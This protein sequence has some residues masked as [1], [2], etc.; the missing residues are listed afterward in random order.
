MPAPAAGICFFDASIKAKNM[1]GRNKSGH[2]GLGFRRALGRCIKSSRSPVAAR[3]HLDQF[4]DLAP[5]FGL[6]AGRNGVLD[7][8]GGVIGEDFLLGAA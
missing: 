3:Q 2:D 1:A 4:A 7:A 8:M 6:V 5:L